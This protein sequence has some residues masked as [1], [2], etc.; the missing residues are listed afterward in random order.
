[1]QM[2]FDFGFLRAIGWHLLAV[3]C[4]FHASIGTGAA[5]NETPTCRPGF[6][7][8]GAVCVP[9]GA[10]GAST[11]APTSCPAGQRLEAGTC[12]QLWNSV[13]RG[14]IKIRGTP[15]VAVGYSGLVTSAEEAKESAVSQCRKSG[16][17]CK[18]VGAWNEGCVYIVVG[19]STRGAGWSSSATIEETTKKCRSNGYSCKTPIGGCVN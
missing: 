6:R 18:A 3:V 2:A 12:Q 10:A 1:M 9:T 11:D 17:N 4:L 19:S 14:I 15:H 16:E 13:A 5:Q 8:E 7:L